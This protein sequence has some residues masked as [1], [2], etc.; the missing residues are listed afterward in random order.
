MKKL[1]LLAASGSIALSSIAQER[2]MNIIREPLPAGVDLSHHGQ[3]IQKR[4][5]RQNGAAQKTTAASPRWYNY[6]DYFY[7]YETSMSS[8]V[9]YSA[10]YLWGTNNALMAFGDG[11]G[12]TVYDTVNF[13]SVG[14]ITDPSYGISNNGFNNADLY[15]GA[16]K[17][18]ATDAFTIDSIL[19]TGIYQ[20]NP[21]KL[22]ASG[23]VDTIRV[24][25]ISG[26]GSTTANI[27]Q[28]TETVASGDLLTSYGAAVGST[29]KYQYMLYN[30]MSKK[31]AGT[32]NFTYDILLNNTTTPPSWAADTADGLFFGVVPVTP[33]FSVPA[34][35]MVGISV[36]FLSGDNT[37]VPGDTVF[38]GGTATPPVKYNM[39]RP[40]IAYKG[41]STAPAW[42][43]YEE[44][45][46]NTGGYVDEPATGLYVPHWFWSAGTSAAT[47]QYPDIAFRVGTCTTCGVVD[48][49]V[50]V[51]DVSN[52]RKTGAFPNP[53]SGDVSIGYMLNNASEAT[54]TITNM[55][56]QVVAT[57]TMA[58][59]KEG[60]AVFNTNNLADGLY[61]YSVSA[62]G[63]RSTG[64]I[65]VAH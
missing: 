58:S 41:S 65:S 36:T 4:L 20:V 34:G 47:S 12:G 53:T 10:A 60:V 63:E 50:G 26:N 43:T 31:A 62:N 3:T 7:A 11:A 8:S 57:K 35:N 40:I 19:F 33:G 64:R 24:S 32:P 38:I 9:A 25:L 51:A 45:N 49:T 18:T 5:M 46:R 17:I 55:L 37:F 48:G 61:T 29:F 21:A 1:F 56:G 54:I 22:G 28:G 13:I 39:F 6:A 30:T 23:F 27:R 2:T 16:M 15:S 42:L 14:A 52:I 44:A 59:A